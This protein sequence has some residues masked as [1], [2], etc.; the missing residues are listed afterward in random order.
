MK[1][2]TALY[3]FRTQNTG[4]LECFSGEVLTLVSEP[5]RG[6]V[7]AKNASG[8][9]GFVPVSYVRVVE[10]ATS[11][12]AAAATVSPGRTTYAKEREAS[13]LKPMGGDTSSVMPPQD[14]VE[15]F[16]RNEVY[17]KQLLK[18]RQEAL[19]KL[20]ASLAEAH[21]EVAACK[22]KNSQLGRRL[23]D[24]T[25]IIDAERK[26]WRDRV[27]A[28]KLLVQQRTSIIPTIV[29]SATIMSTVTSTSVVRD[30]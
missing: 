21:S 29:P 16:M 14:V 13:A 20:E 22:D 1:R 7:R 25:E 19:A 15:A 17:H 12:S 3:D 6:W 4:E 26:K 9:T 10:P 2:C 5:D 24:L 8:A 28:E 18:Q 11:T 27:E 23:K 30:M